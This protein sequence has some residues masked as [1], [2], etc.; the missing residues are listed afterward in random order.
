MKEF[1]SD[2]PEP[3]DLDVKIILKRLRDA[4]IK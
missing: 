1:N 2:M 3:T 4:K